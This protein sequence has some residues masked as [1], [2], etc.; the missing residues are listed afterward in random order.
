[1]C[2][3]FQDLT[4]PEII[5]EVAREFGLETVLSQNLQN[6][7]QARIYCVQYRESSFAFISRL[8]EQEGIYYYFDHASEGPL[9]VLC[10]DISCHDAVPGHGSL[11]LRDKNDAQRHLEDHIFTWS[12]KHRS[13]SLA[14]TLQDYDFEKSATDLLARKTAP[15]AGSQKVPAIERYDYP[16][17]HKTAD[18][19]TDRA[20]ARQTAR[21]AQLDEG[22][23]V[24][25][26]RALAVGQKF[27]LESA[28]GGSSEF[29]VTEGGYQLYGLKH[30][31][32]EDQI[33][34]AGA[35][36]EEG[37]LC[38]FRAIPASTRFAKAATTPIPTI[39]GLQTAVVVGKSGEEIYTDAFGRIKVQFHWDR[40]GEKDEN[41]TCW[42]RSVVPWSGKGWGMVALPRIGQEV[43][44][45][46]EEGNPDRPICTGML[47]ND[48]HTPP[49]S[50]P[51]NKTQSGVKTNSSKGGG[52]FHELVFEDKK[53]AEFVR[54]Q[55]ER[56]YKQIV[57]NN[58][59]ITIGMEHQDKGDLTETIYRHK[60]QT[61]ETGD[62]TYTIKDGEQTI[63]IK[64][65]K[66]ETI[67]GKNTLTVT[68]NLATTVKEGDVTTTVN[69]GDMTTAVKLGNVTLD[70]KAGKIAIKAM[71][72]I[73]LS[74]GGSSITIDMSGITIK[75]P[76]VTV[77]GDITAD[78]K[79]PMT[80][81][82]A[83]GILTLKGSLTMI[84]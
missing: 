45:Q 17:I 60:T 35:S 32:V 20:L 71:Q 29:T 9:M 72:E 69:M 11:K 67:E 46:F 56:D 50:L 63:K 70:A 4:V 14:V 47:Y 76:T 77:Q 82:N 49:Y 48:A 40:D 27:T 36:E 43:V 78:V 66:T 74:V 38:T 79:A 7:Y 84:N 61:L 75:G 44:I 58:A 25:N 68:D 59:E 80:T 22:R 28:V 16:G 33:G 37:Y 19:G 3:I 34:E 15:S 12:Q 18:L 21:S 83:N 52:G 31:E 13:V 55:S 1:D 41:T 23:G 65:D 2:R 57:K 73:K 6:T 53:D 5:M 54:F 64:K 26:V 30:A 39:P 24:C 81:V 42:V 62:H 10:D 51:D 8:M